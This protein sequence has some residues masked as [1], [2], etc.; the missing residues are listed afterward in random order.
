MVFTRVCCCSTFRKAWAAHFPVRNLDALSAYPVIVNPTH[1]VGDEGWFSD[2]EPPPEILA[3]IRERKKK[4]EA[5]EQ[6]KLVKKKTRQ[7]IVK[8]EA[9]NRRIQTMRERL[10]TKTEL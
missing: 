9:L 1:Y 5:D 8:E 7:E 3:E 2:T 10:K 4:E 6:R